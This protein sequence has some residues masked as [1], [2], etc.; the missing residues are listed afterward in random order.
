MAWTKKALIRYRTIDRCLQNQHRRWTLEDLREACTEALYDLEGR[1]IELSRRTIQL[2]LQLMRSEKLGYEAPIE[3]YDR[4]YYRYADPDFK[5]S[6]I[7]LNDLD[8]E[9][10]NESVEILRQF[11]DFSLFRDLNGVI[12]KL[13]D[14]IHRNSNSRAIIH[15]DKNEQLKGLEF[16]D[17]IYQAIQ[18]EIVLNINYQSFSNKRAVNFK[19]QPYLLKEFNNRWFV[20]GRKEGIGR[21]FNLALDRIQSIDLDLKSRYEPSDFDPDEYYKNTFG[22]TVLSDRD[23]IDIEIWINPSNAPYVV[24]KPIHSSQKTL[25]TYSDGSVIVGFKVHHNFEIERHLLGYAD[26]IRVLKPERLVKRMHYKLSKAAEQYD[27]DFH[28]HRIQE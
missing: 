24:T 10:I 17:E 7:P 28:L 8:L 9:V 12:Q 5:I 18:K 27:R 16:L 4:K 25:E 15:L 3:V 11:K 21:I 1:K 23:L 22:V 20:I 26:N 19:L 6:D 13:E 2:D 14:K